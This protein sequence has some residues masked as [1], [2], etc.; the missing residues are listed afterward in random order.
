MIAMINDDS[1][2]CKIEILGHDNLAICGG[3]YCKAGCGG[4]INAVM[5]LAWLAIQNAL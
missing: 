4:Y 5:R 3:S 2:A 1:A